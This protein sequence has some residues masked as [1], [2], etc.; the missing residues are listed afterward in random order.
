MNSTF[1]VGIGRQ[2]ITPKIGAWL[3][4]YAPARRAESVGDRL[5]LTAYAFESNG[6]LAL[7][8]TADVCIID[9]EL[10]K[11]VR[12]EISDISGVPYDNIIICAT[13]THSGPATRGTAG[14]ADMD[15]EYVENIF[16]PAAKKA[17]TEAMASLRPALMGIGEI[18]SNVGVNRREILPD[19]SV[20][21]GQNPQGTYDPIMTVV[22]FIE[23]NGKPIGNI[24][25]YGAHNTAAGKNPEIT[26]DWCGPAIDKLEEISGGITSFFN[27][28]EGDCG[29]RLPN[30]K[31]AA[32]YLEA[33]SLGEK[34]ALDAV[35]AW[36]SISE[37]HENPTLKVITKDICLPYK[38]MPTEEELIKEI[39]EMGDPANLGGL[40]VLSYKALNKRLDLL[41]SNQNIETE[42]A[43]TTTAVCIGPLAFFP[44]PFEIFSRITLSIRKQSPFRYTLSLSNANGT[45]FYFPSIDQIP[46]GGYEIWA[47][48]TF[49]VQPFADDSEHHLVEGAI[50]LLNS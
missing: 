11:T 24:I 48:T 6:V 39:E 33:L 32:N 49:N 8:A 35:S 19:G 44:I 34:A 50:K 16:V 29:P 18:N 14:G 5:N 25:H 12:R 42:K 22:S 17:A 27:G 21:L 46:L 31:T 26:R 10:C 9:N 13:H 41:R 43:F 4:G 36:R 28:C 15:V 30:G 23:P 1:K 2:D 38:A 3:M 37:W 47:F 7:V 20:A 40:R 45:Y